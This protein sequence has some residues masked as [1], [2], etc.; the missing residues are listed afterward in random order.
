MK[1]AITTLCGL[2][3]F[4]VASA[5]NSDSLTLHRA[6]RSKLRV[7]K[8]QGYVVSAELFGRPQ[9]IS[10][11]RLSPERF[12]PQLVM[13]RTLTR[14]SWWG[15]QHNAVVGI[16]AGF[17]SV[18]RGIPSTYVRIDGRDESQSLGDFPWINGVVTLD[19]GVEVH[20]CDKEEYGAL[21]KRYD[22]ILGTGPVL[23]DEGYRLPYGYISPDSPDFTARQ[24][25]FFLGRHPRTAIGRDAKGVVYLVVVDGRHKGIAEGVS[26]PELGLLCRWLG[27]VEA[28][29][30]DGGG[31]STLWLRGRG[32]VN[33]PS[34]NKRYDHEGERAVMSAI[35][36]HR[37]R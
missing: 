2:L 22:N 25:R 28:I 34:D 11:V 16:N 8:A 35:L 5:T 33:H 36:F 31:S 13:T 14:T 4:V 30:L 21:A 19:G 23:I 27:M 15:M 7:P 29:N 20:L 12:T 37:K 18:R 9:N 32:V 26:I 1:R 24:K 3:L 10:V 6:S 17:W